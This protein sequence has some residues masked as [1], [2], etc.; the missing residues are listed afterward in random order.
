MANRP[1]AS[2]QPSTWT[3]DFVESFKTGQTEI[4]KER[5]R[6]LEEEVRKMVDDEDVEVEPTAL[7]ELVDII[8]RLGLGYIFDKDIKRALHRIISVQ[9]KSND[10]KQKSL[11]ATALSFRLLRQH[12]YQ[13]S[14]GIL[15][16]FLKRKK[17]ELKINK[18]SFVLH[19]SF[20]ISILYPFTNY[21][22]NLR[23][24]HG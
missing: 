9:A 18:I 11:H 14:Q 2:Y 13:V 7:L 17:K 3:Y 24:R 10:R 21:F 6:K 20:F 5:Q 4:Y 16:L 12:G 19:I 22:T 23:F 1:S 15:H 8:Q